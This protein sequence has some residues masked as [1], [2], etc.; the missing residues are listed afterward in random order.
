MA[1]KSLDTVLQY[2]R[3]VAMAGRKDGNDA[4]LLDRFARQGDELAFERL[5]VLHGP[6]VLGVCGRLLR[7]E[8]DAEDAF[9]ATFLTLARKA[10]TIGKKESLASWLYKVAYRVACR[11]RR[12]VSQETNRMPA[13]D[14]ATARNEADVLARELRSVLD[15]EIAALPEAYRR[16]VVLCY[17]QDKTNEEAARL[18][19]CPKGTIMSRLAQARVLLRR[20]L[21]RRGL[22]LST[23]VLMTVLSDKALAASLPP[24][25]VASTMAYVT[26]KSANA[27]ALSAKVFA[28]SD[29]VLRMLWLNKMKMAAGVVLAVVLAGAGVGLVVRETWAGGEGQ[30]GEPAAGAQKAA[31]KAGAQEGMKAEIEELKNRVADLRDQ[32]HAALKEI[33]RLAVPP[34]KDAEVK[35]LLKER[36]ETLAEAADLLGIQYR[37]GSVKFETFAAARRDALHASLD[38]FESPKERISALSKL[39]E[40]VTRDF[41]MAQNSYEVGK[42]TKIAVNQAKAIMLEARIALLRE[43]NKASPK[44][45]RD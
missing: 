9:Q 38:L 21:S 39:L 4:H 28:L 29:G 31:P 23:A 7:R 35:K 10:K 24:A 26:G 13:L 11:L 37:Q 2:L 34:D 20:R 6:M 41:E 25:L 45:S 5:M 22:T 14:K 44:K 36:Y 18:L 17:L 8:Q 1:K 42:A 15:A 40:A 33:Q 32:L 30:V 12:G 16:P 27:G 43:E 3:R 19:G